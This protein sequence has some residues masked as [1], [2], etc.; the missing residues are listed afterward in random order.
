MAG[1]V[2]RAKAPDH[3]L[4]EAEYLKQLSRDRSPVRV[5]TNKDEDFEGT[6]EFFDTSFVR[7]T[8]DGAP[9]LFIFKEDIKYIVELGSASSK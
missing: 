1:K 2:S 8:R 5:R 9:N 6:I 3:T 4:K 7:L